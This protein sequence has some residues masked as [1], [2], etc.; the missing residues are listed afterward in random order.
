MSEKRVRKTG[1]NA[2]SFGTGSAART[3]LTVTEGRTFVMTDL[4]VS[5]GG[6]VT[7]ATAASLCV[8]LFDAA[9]QAAAAPTATGQ[10]FKAKIPSVLFTGSVIPQTL[11][12]SGMQN[13]P[14]FKTAVLGETGECTILAYGAFI[15][16]Y[17]Y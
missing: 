6:L 7:K 4:I 8:N 16:G 10:K 17:E 5:L 9:S 13:G 3:L 2:N 1:I 11:I 14:E 15:G 12:V